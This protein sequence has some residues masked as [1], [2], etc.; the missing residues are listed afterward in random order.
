[1]LSA[2]CCDIRW[3]VHEL[4][5][6]LQVSNGE[7]SHSGWPGVARPYISKEGLRWRGERTIKSIVRID[8]SIVKSTHTDADTHTTR[9]EPCAYWSPTAN[10]RFICRQGF[11]TIIIYWPGHRTAVLARFN[12]SKLVNR[13]AKSPHVFHVLFFFTCLLFCWNKQI[14]KPLFVV[15]EVL[16]SVHSVSFGSWCSSR[17]EFYHNEIIKITFGTSTPASQAGLYVIQNT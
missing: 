4:P 2:V 9:L 1:M 12:P 6:L 13:H 11:A 7:L 5:K 14:F 3:A 16:H 15:A 10:S 8:F 17:G